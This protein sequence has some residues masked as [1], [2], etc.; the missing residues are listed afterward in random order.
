MLDFGAEYFV[1]CLLLKN[2]KTK[3]YTNISLPVILYGSETWS[4]TLRKERRQGVFKYRALRIITGTERYRKREGR[5]LQ[6]KVINDPKF[7][8]KIS[9]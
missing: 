2:V 4:L 7:S 8:P 6:S 3:I 1:S 9:C 5:K